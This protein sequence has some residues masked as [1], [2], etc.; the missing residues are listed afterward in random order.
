M[1]YLDKTPYK[2]GLIEFL[3]K[4]ANNTQLVIPVYQ[5]NYTWKVNSEIKPF[6]NDIYSVVKG[7]FV[8]HFMGIIIYNVTKSSPFYGNEYS[9]IDGQQRITTTVLLLYAIRDYLYDNNKEEAAKRIENVY[10]Y[11]EHLENDMKLKLKPLVSDDL[12]LKKIAERKIYDFD[13]KD[14]KSNIYLNY[15]EIKKWLN[16]ILESF[17][18][19]D[20]ISG[21]N[22]LYIICVPIDNSDYPQKIFESINSKGVT[23]TS[24]DLIRNFIFMGLENKI[25]EEYYNFYWKAIEDNISSDSRKLEE[26]LR[27]YIAS[28]TYE[29]SNTKNNGVY[30]AFKDMLEKLYD[31]E[32]NNQVNVRCTLEKIL[33][34]SK[35]YSA[36]YYSNY[37]NL[38]AALVKALK[39]FKCVDSYM[40]APLLLR[41]FDYFSSE[42]EYRKS[43]IT[44]QQLIRIIEITTNYLMRRSLANLDTSDISRL[45]APL[46]FNVIEETKK[47][48]FK[49]IVE[50]YKK[51]LI[52]KNFGKG[53][54]CPD[55]SELKEAVLANSNMY[56]LKSTRT[57]LDKFELNNNPA[58]V[59]LSSLSVEHLMPQTHTKEWLEYLNCDETKYYNYYN[60]LGNLTLAAKPDNSRMSNN[61]FDYKQEIL[62][63]TNHLNINKEILQKTEWKFK[64]IDERTLLFA[65]RI[66]E[67]FPYESAS[68]A[69]LN[70]NP[71]YLEA[72]GVKCQAIYDEDTYS[73]EILPGS[74]MKNKVD[75]FNSDLQ[76]ST[77][78]ELLDDGIIVEEDNCYVFKK[79]YTFY[80]HG[81]ATALSTSAGFVLNGS[82]NGWDYWKTSSGVKLSKYYNHAY[83]ENEAAKQDFIDEC[84][85]AINKIIIKNGNVFQTREDYHNKYF[86]FSVKKSF[87]GFID[88]FDLNE[89]YVNFGIW[90]DN[91][92]KGYDILVSN[93]KLFN[94]NEYVYICSESKT[95][96]KVSTKI[97]L[98]EE[99]DEFD[100]NSYF[101]SIYNEIDRILK[102]AKTLL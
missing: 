93:I 87:H 90:F 52:N 36:I 11:N 89:K 62:A 91:K 29:L 74:T 6:L 15:I 82:R 53:S 30:H 48:G 69:V 20:I 43:K 12:A 31:K 27:F 44:E 65:D 101:E 21:I 75:N 58:P 7:E 85:N 64:E 92:E 59:D 16:D 18:V 57:L 49:N 97:P 61:P 71:I 84:W 55:N 94:T 100:Y 17:D 4:F 8:N 38:S 34:Y 40:P 46:T 63:S 78:M 79:D 14:K 42:N 2:C 24:S 23:L 54:Y 32:I 72:E 96:A 76:L 60:R 50:V 98:L 28:Q 81:N 10:L 9:I 22:K 41:M 35:Y 45:F 66:N 25:Q 26:F 1:D 33:R 102:I 5:R 39:S 86:N 88:F 56:I 80:A 67:L 68:K 73:V 95:T 51:H 77:F 70:K 99:N 83:K 47:I 13:E 3:N 19:D 37:N